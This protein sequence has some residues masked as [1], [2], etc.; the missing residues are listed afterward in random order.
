MKPI[1]LFHKLMLGA[2]NLGMLMAH[3]YERHGLTQPMHRI[4]SVTARKEQ[5]VSDISRLSGVSRQNVQT[6]VNRMLA[7]GLIE[8]HPN[9][10]DKRAPLLRPTTAGQ[11]AAS[12]VETY[13]QKLARRLF[14]D[15]EGDRIAELMKALNQALSKES[16]W[17][18]KQ[19]QEETSHLRH[20]RKRLEKD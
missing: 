6:M 19:E 18:T 20:L 13:M 12:E 17:M 8:S 11:Q 5:S 3:V 7:A 15:I 10:R 14:T 9:P 1:D 4:L 16:D 2:E